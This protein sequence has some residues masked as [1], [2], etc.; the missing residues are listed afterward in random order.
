[1]AEAAANDLAFTEWSSPI[2]RLLIAENGGAVVRLALPG[3]DREGTLASLAHRFAIRPLRAAGATT[4]RAI[5]EL[6]S[7]FSGDGSD[8]TVP[9]ATGWPAGFRS[10]VLAAT[11]AIPFAETRSYSQVAMAAGSARASRAAGS[12]LAANPVA[13]IIPCHRV[14]RSDGTRGRYGGG[15]RLKAT[16]LEH[17]AGVLAHREGR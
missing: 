7:Y 4:D 11:S 13:L 10:S 2:G 3:Y 12:S 8:F 14:I 17:E 6:A 9:V 1:M 15:S 5:D 16:L